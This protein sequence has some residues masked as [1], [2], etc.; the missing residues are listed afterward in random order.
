MSSDINAALRALYAAPTWATAFEVAEATGA[1]ARRRADMVAVNCYPS[2]GMEIHGCEVKVSRSDWL[3]EIKNPDKVEQGAYRFC[4][5]WWVATLPGVVK[6]EELPPTWGLYE[7]HG[8][9]LK[10]QVKAPKLTPQPVDV[11]FLASL[12][13]NVN[14]PGDAEVEALAAQKVRLLQKTHEESLHHNMENHRRQ[15]E[16]IQAQT[17]TF[18]ELVGH[19]WNSLSPAGRQEVARILGLI[20]ELDGPRRYALLSSAETSLQDAL[21]RVQEVRRQLTVPGLEGGGA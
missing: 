15:I 4:D 7:L 17:K 10:V 3:R 19:R 11:G 1:Y 2:Q 8:P 12:L 16:T 13:R 20:I 14:K 18:D 21:S 6:A 5:R 9:R